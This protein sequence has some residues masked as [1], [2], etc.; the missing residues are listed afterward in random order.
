MAIGEEISYIL[1]RKNVKN[2]NLRVKRD[3]SVVVSANP[4]VPKKYID[5]FVCSK[6]SFIQKAQAGMQQNAKHNIK[7]QFITG[8]QIPYL[9]SSLCLQ[10][11]KADI[12]CV[13][14]W[15]QQ[16]QQGDITVFSRN[17][18]GEAVFCK[19]GYLYLYTAD[20]S[21]TEYKQQ[22][23]DTWQKIQTGRLCRQ[24][25]KRY[26][27]V[28]EKLGVAFPEIKIRK[29]S[30]RWGSCVPGR[31]KVTFNS[32]LLEKPLES[33]EYVVVHEFSHFIHPNHSH[34]FYQFV[35]GILPDWKR[36][37]EGLC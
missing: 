21:N 34:A 9:G 5:Q 20:D 6:S 29:M 26:Y 2:I 19:D 24:I 1:I 15:M 13:P 25:S 16:V 7:Q 22:L 27:P 35:E 37:K 36:R 31:Q 17:E 10:V 30:S 14:E 3:G 8:E 18:R 23:Y 28:F 4:C 12:R 11:N 33:I 32:L